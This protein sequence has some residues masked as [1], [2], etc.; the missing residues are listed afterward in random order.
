ML[1]FCFK[2]LAVQVFVVRARFE[3]EIARVEQHPHSVFQVQLQFDIDYE[4]KQK[5]QKMSFVQEIK[6]L[7]CEGM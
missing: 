6:L 5:P 4:R 1:L 3:L 7:G 2:V